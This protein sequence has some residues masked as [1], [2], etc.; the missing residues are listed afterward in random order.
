[1][2]TG[3]LDVGEHDF[4]QT[5]HARHQCRCLPFVHGIEM[6][7]VAAGDLHGLA[8][9][10]CC[11]SVPQSQAGDELAAEVFD[12][13][14]GKPHIAGQEL[15]PD[16][17]RVAMPPEQGL[18]H[19]NQDIVGDIAAAGH[20]PEQSARVKRAGAKSA[21]SHRLMCDEGP[22]HAQHPL[23]PCL[24]HEET[25]ATGADLDLGSESHNR[26]PRKKDRGHCLL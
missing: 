10:R 6:E 7:D 14:D 9:P 15:G 18:S 16:L 26:R 17:V 20:Q 13:R 4:A 3:Q 2:L 25:A 21:S 1:V 23:A 5:V 12:L 11:P 8:N 24:L 22:D 19:E